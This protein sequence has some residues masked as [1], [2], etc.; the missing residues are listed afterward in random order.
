MTSPR[1]FRLSQEAA[2][3]LALLAKDYGISENKIVNL[4]L[5]EKSWQQYMENPTIAAEIVEKYYTNKVH[6]KMAE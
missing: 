3:N 6:S 4:L 5:T 1:S 2:D